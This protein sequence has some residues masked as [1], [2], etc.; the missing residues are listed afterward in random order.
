MLITEAKIVI[1]SE[2]AVAWRSRSRAA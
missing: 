1:G 2:Q